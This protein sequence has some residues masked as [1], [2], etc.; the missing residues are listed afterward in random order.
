ME[1]F[2]VC[3]PGLEAVCAAE[4]RALGLACT[5]VAGGVELMGDLATVALL[6]L[7]LRTASRVLVRLGTVKATAFA[8]LVK[9]ARTLPWEM[10]L[11]RGTAAAIRATCRKSR[12]YHSDA[13][14]ERL[15]TALEERVGFAVGEGA[16]DAPGVQ[17]FVARFE[18]DVCTVSADT[19]GAL[20]HQRGYRVAPGPAP[21]RETLAA[22]ILLAA[23]FDGSLPLCDPLCGGG[24]IA[25][26][27]ALIAARRPPGGMRGFAY[28][29][30]PGAR[31]VSAAGAAERPVQVAPGVVPGALPGALI[32]ASDL[33]P[34]AIDATR[35]NAQ[36]ARVQLEIV[37]RPLLEL[38]PRSA[39]GLIACNPPYGLRVGAQQDLAQLYRQLGDLARARRAGWQLAAVVPDPR[40]GR[41]LG[42]PQQ[43]LL[44]TQNGGLPIEVVRV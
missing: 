1:L 15:R 29:Q 18:R 14:A 35:A 17:L 16:E 25:I 40:L 10:A 43:R 27:A 44:K 22:A 33:D 21:M 23:G 12:L 20:L 38:P 32:E 37:Q 11:S 3:Q 13:V 41:A 39:P 31:G 19:S 36:R 9:K 42:T 4:V 26:E 24:T 6:N 8:E 5:Q 7:W 30:W 2:A 28:Q 34:A